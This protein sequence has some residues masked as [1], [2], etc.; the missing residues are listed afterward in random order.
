MIGHFRDNGHMSSSH[1]EWRD[2]VLAYAA[3]VNAFVAR[4]L[5]IGWE[6]A[7]REPP[8]PD[9]G[10]L[11]PNFIEALRHANER[12][13]FGLL[14]EE[15]PP[16]HA[17]LIPWLQKHGRAIPLVRF[18][19]DGSLVARIGTQYEKEAKS[20]HIRGDTVLELPTV[21]AFGRSPNRKYFAFAREDGIEIREGWTGQRTALC[22]WPSGTEDVPSDFEVSAFEQ[23]PTPTRL[24]PF[25]DGGRVLLVSGDGI[26]V[27]APNSVR[28]L[29]PTR[30]QLRD[31][32][33]WLR[34]KYPTDP[35]TCSI[36][37]EHGSVSN[38]GTLIA[39]GEQSS[40]HLLFDSDLQLVLQLAPASEYP[41]H[42]VFSADDTVLALNSCHFYSGTTVGIATAALRNR[43]NASA[44]EPFQLQDG[45]RVYAAV[46][47]NDEFIVGDAS[48]YVRAFDTTGRYRWQQ[49]IGS[50]VGDIDLSADGRHLAVST[51]A[52][53]LSIFR[54]DAG[55][56]HPYQIGN[57]NHLEECRWIFWKGERAP[58]IW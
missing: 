26:F 40:A 42:A 7:G 25:P 27:L 43:A 1:V 22:P 36:D 4:G 10:H 49:F 52:G 16:A 20:V 30:E 41:H 31:H 21:A 6:A 3:N 38:D 39:V 28:R 32:F 18:L 5:S 45:A 48:G 37:M 14:R 13:T 12:G 47:R 54:L 53:F 55:E 46:A 11:V 51:Y 34:E 56:Q 8:E 23:H 19:D 44:Q 2:K 17:P 33:S 50:S 35:L 57:G 15:W 9:L 24:V 58:L 29:L